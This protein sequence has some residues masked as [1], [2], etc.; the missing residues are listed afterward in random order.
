MEGATTDSRLTTTPKLRQIDPR[1]EFG[2]RSF[3]CG[4]DQVK[5]IGRSEPH[6]LLAQEAVISAGAPLVGDPLQTQALAQLISHTARIAI[7]TDWEFFQ[8]FGNA[9]AATDYIGDLVGYSS[10]LYGA[11]ID[12]SLQISHISLWS[13]SGDPWG[14]TSTSCGL[15]EFGRYWN[16]N[17]GSIQRTTA[18]FLSGKNNGGGVAWLGVLCESSFNVNIGTSCS[19]MPSI[20]NYG[21]AYGYSGQ[22]AGNF[23]INNPALV[24]DVLVFNHELGHNFNSPHTHCYG[25]IGGNSSPVDQ[26]YGGEGDTGCH[27]G[28][29]VLPGPAGQGSGT[30]M[31][32][33]HLLSP[34]L[35]NTDFTFGQG[36]P[37]GVAPDRVPTRMSQYVDTT[38]STYPSCLALQQGAALSVADVTV[39]EGT[40]TATFS[41]NLSAA[42]SGGVTVQYTTANGTATSGSDYSTTSGTLTFTGTANEVRTIS[43]PISNDAMLE[44]NETFV[45]NFSN[46]SKPA[47]T[48]DPSATGTITDNDSASLSVVDIIGSEGSV[49]ALFS[50]RLSAAV[51]GGLTINFATANG[52]ATAGADYTTT[53][54]TLTFTGTA[55][56][57]RTISV[58]IT[59]DSIVDPNE[60]F[61]VNFSTISKP[62]VTFDSQAIGTITDNDSASL[63]VANVTV[64]EGSA[65]ATFSVRLSA[66][67]Q[68][69]LTINFATANGTATAGTDYTTTSG[70]L[71]FTG[72]ANETRTLSVPI[73]NNT[74]VEPNETFVVNFSTISKPVVTFDSQAIGTIT[75]NESASLTVADVAVSEATATATFSVRLSAAVQGGLTINF[76]TANGTATAG[77]DYTT[78]SGTLTFT[79]TANEVRTIS[80]PILNNTIVEANETFVVNFSTISKPVVTFDSQAIGTIL[81]DEGP[82]LLI[83]NVYQAEG[84]SGAAAFTF[85]VTLTQ[86]SASTVT[87]VAASANY[88]ALAGSDYTTL[89]PTTL[90]FAPG[91]KSKTVTVT[92]TG[93]TVAESNEV[94]FVNLSSATNATIFDNQGAGII[95]NDEGPTLR[96]NDVSKAEGNSVSTAFTFT[97]TLAPAKTTG[98]VTVTAASANYSAL[99]GSDY[100]ALPATTL[101]FA[102]GETSK[103]VTVNVTGNT[104]VEPTEIFFVTLS[105]ATGATIFDSQ[106]AGTILNDD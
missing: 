11:E 40:A 104:V 72:T 8:K 102:A 48:F 37:Y 85:T 93:D 92:V 43:V 44:S 20:D 5:Q 45:V 99:A 16:D 66:A 6:N 32:Y 38:A 103:T 97:V 101:T 62:V 65:T 29:G 69:G 100:T 24:W 68:G 4:N 19:G 90:T 78:T 49:T 12:T 30:V 63:S 2:D 26:C 13:N 64:S 10:T 70:T 79:G 47:V 77:T 21:G 73:L 82:L 42:V 27:S 94:F 60:T 17:R 88:S 74:I 105:G 9:T 96:I 91:Q 35:S 58:P 84:H 31:S 89:P 25:G 14:Q 50:V 15:F 39:A 83:N 36:H 52:T 87:V 61:A 106:G 98:P 55:N 41:V 71:A 53:S 67:V 3:Q 33:C 54:G 18:H 75:D 95:L 81:N 51:Q 34:G 46:I 57:V 76:A 23:D 22:L 7:E 28:A 1:A 86:A 56:E 80:V 59:N